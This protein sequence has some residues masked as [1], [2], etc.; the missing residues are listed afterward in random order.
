MDG[1]ERPTSGNESRPSLSSRLN[2][3]LS[4]LPYHQQKDNTHFFSE[5]ST[6]RHSADVVRHESMRHG[7]R[8]RTPS[9]RSSSTALNTSNRTAHSLPRMS[10][11]LS[12]SSESSGQSRLVISTIEDVRCE[13][14][15][16]RNC[17][18][19]DVIP[20]THCF[21]S[22]HRYRGYVFSCCVGSHRAAGQCGG[23]RLVVS[24]IQGQ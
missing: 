10:L 20:T 8:T 2:Y 19:R 24:Q 21:S 23:Q 3:L 6:S 18:W 11:R 14:T 15:L 9:P 17:C 4:S 12:T 1:D 7:A 5:P 13:F 16:R 22:N